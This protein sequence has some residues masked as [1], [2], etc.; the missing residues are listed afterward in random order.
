VHEAAPS[1]DRA[2]AEGPA[3]QIVPE[4]TP[5]AAAMPDNFEALARLFDQ[6]ADGYLHHYFYSEVFPVRVAAG[7]LEFR[8]GANAPTD[9]AARI[10]SALESWTGQRWTVAVSNQAGEPSLR[11]RV[12][13]AE[14]AARREAMAHPVVRAVLD[15]FPDARL[16]AI[17]RLGPV[18]DALDPADQGALDDGDTLLDSEAGAA[19]ISDESSDDGAAPDD[20]PLARG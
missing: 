14:E 16:E 1:T 3:P 4:G 9:L 17:H 2:P 15:Q 20:D 12:A 11:E 18:P 7:H 8:P 5:P 13:N 6:R 19:D 10:A